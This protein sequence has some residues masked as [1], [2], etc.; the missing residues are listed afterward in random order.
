LDHG[1][2]LV[3]IDLLV[4]P[5]DLLLNDGAD[6]VGLEL[7][8]LLLRQNSLH[9]GKPATDRAVEDRAADPNLQSREKLRFRVEGEIHIAPEEVPE[10]AAESVLFGGGERRG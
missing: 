3:D 7:H 8:S 10:T 9:R 1:A 5:F 6:L 2:R 4:E